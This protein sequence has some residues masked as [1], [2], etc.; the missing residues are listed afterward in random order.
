MSTNSPDENFMIDT[1]KDQLQVGVDAGFSGHGFKCCSAV[2]EI[3][4]DLAI[5]GETSYNVDVFTL[6]RFDSR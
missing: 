6:S 4:A 3:M 1:L 2:G 5:R